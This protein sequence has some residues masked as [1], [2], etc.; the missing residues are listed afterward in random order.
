MREPGFAGPGIAVEVW[1]LSPASFGR[2]VSSIPQPLGIGKLLL[3]DGTEVSGFLCEPAALDGAMEITE[4]GG[5][6]NYVAFAG[7]GRLI[8][9]R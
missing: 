4:F 2:F 1:Q 6:R 3:D 9:S 7:Q 5:W 8:L